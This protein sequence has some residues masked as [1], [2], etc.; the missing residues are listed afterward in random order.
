VVVNRTMGTASVVPEL[1][2][3]DVGKAVDWL[4]D[5]FGFEEMWR[6]GN[7]R[8]RIRYGNGI[9]AVADAGEDYGRRV[10]EPGESA[11]CHGVMLQ[12][13]DVDAHH[14]HARQAG[15]RILNTPTDFSFGER[16]YTA[17]DLAGHRWT[18]TQSIADLTPEDWGGTS[19]TR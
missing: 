7:H 15:A 6:V 17:E 18:M 19:K 1:V 11:H 4:C 12:V 2:Y 5:A 8:A 14:D 16:Q 10:P 9:V 3:P 13:E